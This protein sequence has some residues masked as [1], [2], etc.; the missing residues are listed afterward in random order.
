MIRRILIA[1][2]VA[3]AATALALPANAAPMPHTS[4]NSVAQTASGPKV[5]CPKASVHFTQTGIASF[6]M[7]TS[8]PRCT[9]QLSSWAVPDTYDGKGYDAS[10]KPQT[11]V[12]RAVASLTADPQPV[13]VKVPA[14]HW[15]QIDLRA[16]NGTYLYGRIVECHPTATVTPKPPVL[17]CSAHQHK[18]HGK[19]VANVVSK[20]KPSN[21]PAA[22]VR[23]TQASAELPRTGGFDYVL[24]IIGCLAVMFGLSLRFARFT[25]AARRH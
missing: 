8:T 5:T 19:C 22:R 16:A 1:I 11:L 20:P 13:S 14:S 25:R 10:A 23:I 4:G 7:A 12:D 17:N 2:G 24:G 9:V 6:T 15:C 18:S 21:T 3:C